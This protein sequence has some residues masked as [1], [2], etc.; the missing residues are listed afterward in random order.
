MMNRVIGGAN[1][2]KTLFLI[3][4]LRKCMMTTKKNA[5]VFLTEMNTDTFMFRVETFFDNSNYDMDRTISIHRPETTEAMLAKLKELD[6]T[7]EVFIDSMPPS[8]REETVSVK[9]IMDFLTDAPFESL[10]CTQAHSN[11]WSWDT[12]EEHAED[13][14]R[15]MSEEDNNVHVTLVAMGDEME[16]IKWKGVNHTSYGSLYIGEFFK[17][18]LRQVL[19]GIMGE[20]R[21]DNPEPSIKVANFDQ[22]EMAGGELPENLFVN[23]GSIDEKGEHELYAR[24]KGRRVRITV[25]TID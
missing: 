12:I 14:A 23:F 6:D 22:N 18:K 8:K 20:D 19:E 9:E 25:E 10:V 3:Y 21:I 11:S 4:K 7:D 16:D 24:F 17:P 15:S 5:H 1:S 2:G 13:M